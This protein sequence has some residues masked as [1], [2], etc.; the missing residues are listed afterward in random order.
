MVPRAN[1]YHFGT[2][3]TIPPIRGTLASQGLGI[4][5]RPLDAANVAQSLIR[6]TILLRQVSDMATRTKP[7]ARRTLPCMQPWAAVAAVG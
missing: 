6:A 7:L 5:E 1:V 4:R 2:R 3:G